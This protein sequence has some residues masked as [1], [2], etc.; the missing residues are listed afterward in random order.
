MVGVL[1]FF[2]LGF[3]GFVDFSQIFGSINQKLIHEH[4]SL[5]DFTAKGMFI[6]FD[7]G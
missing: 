4:S 5:E 3:L 7:K 6:G 2:E 1:F